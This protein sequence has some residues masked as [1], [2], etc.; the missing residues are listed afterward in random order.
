MIIIGTEHEM[1]FEFES[2]GLCRIIR[3]GKKGRRSNESQNIFFELFCSK[4]EPSSCFDFFG[5]RFLFDHNSENQAE[6]DGTTTM[7]I[8]ETLEC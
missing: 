5:S 6:P 2:S 4:E 3:S 1:T 7:L 8:V